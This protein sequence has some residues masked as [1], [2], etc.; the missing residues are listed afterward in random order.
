MSSEYDAPQSR[1]DDSIG[2]TQR[3]TRILD[4]KDPCR[5]GAGPDNERPQYADLPDFNLCLRDAGG[6]EAAAASNGH[7]YTRNSNPTTR[8]LETKIA[9]LEGAEAALAERRAWPSLQRAD[10][11]LHNGDHVVYSSEV[12][13]YALEFFE[14]RA[15]HWN[16]PPRRST[17]RTWMPSDLQSR[18]K[19]RSSTASFSRTRRIQVANIPELVEIAREHDLKMVVDNTFTSLYLFR[20]IE[21]GVD[22]SLHS[23]TKYLC[24]TAT[25]SP[26]RWPATKT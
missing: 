3:S 5:R 18:P 24:A 14:T 11:L 15:E 22:L 6:K 10:D 12:Y 1:R 9:A 19:R 23:A 20:P 26:A 7:F 13:H 4:G 8:A 25:L 16:S 21:H 17:S 2:E